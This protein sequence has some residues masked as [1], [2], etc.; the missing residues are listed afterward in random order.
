MTT[1]LLLRIASIISLLFAA[2]HTLGGR[3]DWSPAGETDVLHA[4]RTVR[5]EVLGVSRTYLDF[6]RG[7]G[8]T[9]SVYML[10]QAVVLWQLASLARS[11]PSRVRGMVA[12][13]AVAS[14]AVG[15]LS[16]KFIFP[17]PVVFSAVLAVCL[18]I[19]FLTAR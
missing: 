18:V 10:L 9:L 11:E 2:G 6:Y 13:F 4:M 12:S 1:S 16:W 7:F 17:L 19:A 14:V 8:F 3:H 5:F 15:L